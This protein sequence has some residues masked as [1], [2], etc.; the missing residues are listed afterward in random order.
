MP[1]RAGRRQEFRANKEVRKLARERVGS[2]P[3]SK[4]IQPKDRRKTPKH[5]KKELDTWLE[6]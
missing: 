5:P 4:V 1:R 2:V 3:S 6:S